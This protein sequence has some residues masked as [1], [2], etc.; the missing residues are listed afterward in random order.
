[1][2]VPRKTLA[3]LFV[4]LATTVGVLSLLLSGMLVKKLSQEERQKMEVW[5]KAA[6][7]ISRDEPDVDMSLVLM[8]L[9]GNSSI[10][11]ILHDEQSDRLVSHNIRLSK[12]DTAALLRE[13]MVQF[14]RRHEPLRLPELDQTLY[15][16]DSS[17]LK[18]LQL[19]PYIQLF[20]IALFVA[21]A[22][23]ALNRSQRAEQNSV[24]VG[25]S[26]E[27][28]HQL[29]TPISSL[30]AW[31]EYLKLKE[32]DT[33]LLAEIEKDTNRLQMIAE[34]FSR[35][36]SA[37]D[38]QVTD[39][40]EAV[41]E[42]LSYLGKRLSDKIT[43]SLLF[44]S[45]PVLVS[46]NK[47]LFGWVIENLTKNAADAMRGEGLITFSLTEKKNR[48]LFDVADSGKGIQRAN[49]K[50]IFTPGYTTKERGWGLGL[51]LVKRIVEVQHKGEIF[52]LKSESEKGATFRI[53]LRKTE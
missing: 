53:V 13:K 17:T 48:V 25:L 40:R 39:L 30:V 42:T 15:F 3:Y 32:M 7:S 27:T 23:F 41:K 18:L 51:T 2:M 28:A 46:I 35:I 47:P 19:F 14:S 24:W 38:L 26:K 22:F 50:K 31:T 29:G 11:A 12:D 16:D 6:E 5:A 43:F 49:Q 37:T 4:I 45:E 20:V 8:I 21:L 36:G 33:E 34:R 10:P 52:L 1:M 9:Q 44:P